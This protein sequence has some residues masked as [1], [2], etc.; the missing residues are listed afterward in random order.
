MPVPWVA[1]AVARDKRWEY[2]GENDLHESSTLARR[3]VCTVGQ[4]ASF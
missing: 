3:S 4:R 1:V 2:G